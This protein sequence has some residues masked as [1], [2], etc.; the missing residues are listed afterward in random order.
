MDLEVLGEVIAAGKL[1]LA[2]DA[3]VRLDSGV[4]ATVAGQLVRAGEPAVAKTVTTVHQKSSLEGP[5]K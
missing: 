2:D 5:N 3:L 1:L 4:G